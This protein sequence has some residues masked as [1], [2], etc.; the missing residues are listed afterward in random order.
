MDLELE[1]FLAV[2]K[3]RKI[4]LELELK[5]Y[6]F[7]MQFATPEMEAFDKLMTIV[8]KLYKEIKFLEAKLNEV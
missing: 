1:C 8:E 5:D 7:A 4:H 6:E 3:V 2:V